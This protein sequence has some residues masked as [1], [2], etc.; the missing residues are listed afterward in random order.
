MSLA[1]EFYEMAVEMLGDPEIGFDGTLK[2]KVTTQ[3]PTDPW[4][5]IITEETLAIRLF[6]TDQKA[7]FVNG[8]AILKGEK[9][10]LCYAPQGYTFANADGA[11]FIDHNGRKWKVNAVESIG[12]GNQDIVYYLK[13]GV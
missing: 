3:N 13:I 7:G 4:K 1:D 2:L 5:P 6:Y 12:A 9:V 8:S 10:F 11:S